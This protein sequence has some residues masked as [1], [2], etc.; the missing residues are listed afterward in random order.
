MIQNK[1]VKIFV[2][3]SPV[4]TDSNRDFYFALAGLE[5]LGVPI[6]WGNALGNGKINPKSPE[7]AK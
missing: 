1:D 3:W 6:S 5:C 2:F 7:E 4:L